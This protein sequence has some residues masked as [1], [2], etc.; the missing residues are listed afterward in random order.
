MTWWRLVLD[1]I[2]GLKWVGLIALVVIVFRSKISALI[3]RIKTADLTAGGLNVK[4]DLAGQRMADLAQGLARPDDDRL[5]EFDDGPVPTAP[6]GGRKAAPLS[7]ERMS[8]LARVLLE[9]RR[10]AEIE[11]LITDAVGYGWDAAK[12][13]FFESRP[14]PLFEWTEDGKP[15]IAFTTSDPTEAAKR[16]PYRNN[17]M[18]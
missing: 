13:G 17:M 7:Q 2:N 16:S 1:Y 8:E 9:R 15:R 18:D 11:D 5:S 12:T 14:Y 10:R 3:D 4:L 6:D